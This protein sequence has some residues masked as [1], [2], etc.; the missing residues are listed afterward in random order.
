MVRPAVGTCDVGS[1]FLR[2]PCLNEAVASCVYCG[3]RFCADHGERGPEFIDTCSR[4]GC[5]KKQRDVVEHLEWKQGGSDKNR[6]AIC[7]TEDCGE[8]M[9]HRCSRCL[10]MF[11]VE[12]VRNM[13]MVSESGMRDQGQIVVCQH[14]R[15]RRGIW[16]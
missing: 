2:Q 14:C 3:R 9:R 11:C 1:G 15:S 8:R 6:G 4:R 10:L 12:H 16:E 13:R 5:S 7:A